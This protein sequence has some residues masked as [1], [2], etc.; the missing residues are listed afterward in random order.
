MLKDTAVF[1]SPSVAAVVDD[2]LNS[3]VG[4][5]QVSLAPGVAI[6]PSVCSDATSRTHSSRTSSGIAEHCL[7]MYSF[8]AT[9]ERRQLV[10]GQ[11]CRR[12]CGA[13]VR[14][15]Q[16]RQAP[17]FRCQFLVDMDWTWASEEY[18]HES[19]E[20]AFFVAALARNLLLISPV[21]LVV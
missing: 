15:M 9:Q 7:S 3:R 6:A 16:R 2:M 18:G 21:R 10:R 4:S 19:G 12:C 17:I 8:D 1:C 11:V 20:P 13:G 14:A 5:P